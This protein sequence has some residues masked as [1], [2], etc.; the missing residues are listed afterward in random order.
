MN[1]GAQRSKIIAFL[2]VP[3]LILVANSAYTAAFGDPSLFYV[4][5]GLLHPFIGLIVT[6]LFAVFITKYRD[7]FAGALGRACLALLGLAAGLGIY[8]ALVG[9][10][11]PHSVALYAHV[12]TAI[13]GL[14]LLLLYLRRRVAAVS[15]RPCNGESLR[16]RAWRPV[17]RWSVALVFVSAA[18]YVLVALYH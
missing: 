17:W 1:M 4:L 10:T 11:R 14:A 8:V 7:A 3:G 2:I 6:L 5:N 9:M 12:A 16:Y 13:A 18:F 15:A